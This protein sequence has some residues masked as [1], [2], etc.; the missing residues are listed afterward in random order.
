L[1]HPPPNPAHLNPPRTPPSGSHDRNLFA[2][3]PVFCLP[4]SASPVDRGES[5][6]HDAVTIDPCRPLGYREGNHGARPMLR[7]LLNF[8]SIVCLVTCVALMGLWVRS[9]WKCDV[10]TVSYAS[11][12]YSVGSLRGAVG[13]G[14]GVVNPSTTASWLWRANSYP[15]GVDE[16]YTKYPPR[17]FLGF[18]FRTAPNGTSFFVPYWFVVLSTGLLSTLLWRKRSWQFTLRSLFIATT[19]LAVVLG[20]IAWLDRAWIGK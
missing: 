5:F 2:A 16:K 12:S 17:S 18:R 6:G 7:R 1:G 13:C 14:V 11:K 20:M 3:L 19:F 4:I 15:P 10:L 8:A 9:Y